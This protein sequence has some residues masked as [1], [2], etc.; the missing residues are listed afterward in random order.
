VKDRSGRD[1]ER[2]SG[3][4][5]LAPMSHIGIGESVM[6]QRDIIPTYKKREWKYPV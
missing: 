4:E 6:I 2:N 3:G 5:N 1:K